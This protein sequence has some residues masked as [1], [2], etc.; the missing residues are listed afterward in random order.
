M[1][2]TVVMAGGSGTRFWP[3]S[4]T[5]MPK[6]LLKLVGEETMIQETVTRCRPL[7]QADQTWIATNAT[8]APEIQRQLPQLNPEHILVEPVPRNTAPCIGLAAIHL[9]KQDPEATMLVVS[10]DHVIRPASGFQ[11]TVQHAV[12]LIDEDS[13]TLVLIGV[14]PNVPATG[15]GYIQTGAEISP[16][17]GPGMKVAAFKEKPDLET[18]QQYLDSGEYLW[19]CGIFV[20]KAQTLLQALKKYEPEMHS[21]LNRIAASIGTP[22]YAT[23]LAEEFASMKSISIDYAIL[24]HSR[25][26]LAVVPAEFE[27]DDVGNW[28][29][30][31]KYFPT[32]ENGN[33]VVG[34]HCGIKTSDS[35]I[36]T[37]DDHLVATFGV[38]HCLIVHTPDATLIAPRDDE[39]AIKD[40]V[41]A[42]KERG[43]ERYL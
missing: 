23:V 2:H 28:S 42:L 24:E 41:N 26:S 13:E 19:N 3:Q 4:R 1:L 43:Y 39:A 20:W 22:E 29:T 27:W 5:A 16:A 40:L 32:D 9:L 38:S 14:P 7:S 18:A 12:N 33:T 36:R 35:I 37:T 11:Q 30:L 8:L 10:S 21:A 17:T 6:Q 15:Y 34:L 25:E 31:Q